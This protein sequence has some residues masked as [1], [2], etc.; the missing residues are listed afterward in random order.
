MTPHKACQPGPTRGTL[1]PMTRH[2]F[3]TLA[4][5]MQLS[6]CATA[7]LAIEGARGFFWGLFDGAVAPIAFII[8]WFSDEVGIYGV[9]N[10]GGWYDFGF[11]LGV[12]VVWGGGT[13]VQCKTA[14]EKKK[15]QEW[16]EISAK[17]EAK[18]MRKLKAW[19]EDDKDT[20]DNDD[21]DEIGDKV[22]KKLK[23]VIREWAEK[24]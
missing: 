7:P 3:L 4:A 11:L 22:E 1:V 19:A 5:L 10:S 18:I 24:D 16:D 23:R 14:E 12:I 21:W 9:P 13:H 17:A 8:S 6:A 2:T 20:P 15:D